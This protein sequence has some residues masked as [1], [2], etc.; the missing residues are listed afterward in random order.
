MDVIDN[1]T[2][3]SE[4][5][6]NYPEQQQGIQKQL[7]E[8]LGVDNEKQL[9]EMLEQLTAQYKARL[10]ETDRTTTAVAEMDDIERMR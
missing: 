1:T 2:F 3:R 8:I 9:V 7:M 5:Q 10:T 4:T 6:I